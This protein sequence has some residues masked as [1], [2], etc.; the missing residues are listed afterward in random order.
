MYICAYERS[1]ICPYAQHV[2]TVELACKKN[3]IG[4]VTLVP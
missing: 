2:C 1:N 4:E 3:T